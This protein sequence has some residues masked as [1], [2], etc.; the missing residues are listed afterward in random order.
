M[1]SYIWSMRKVAD[2]TQ[3]RYIKFMQSAV[4]AL[5]QGLAVLLLL[6]FVFTIPLV[7]VFHVHAVDP[8]AG[9]QTV[10]EDSQARPFSSPHTNF[11]EICSRLHTTFTFSAPSIQGSQTNYEYEIPGILA[12][13]PP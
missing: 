8:M 13:T 7:S 5:K 2:R 1:L 10:R 4:N 11:C 6:S 12:C 9:T 3:N